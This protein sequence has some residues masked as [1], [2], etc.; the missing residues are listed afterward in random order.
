MQLHHTLRL[1]KIKTINSQ[2]I[3]LPGKFKFLLTFLFAWWLVNYTR[4][5]S[6]LVLSPHAVI[7]LNQYSRKNLQLT[8]TKPQIHK[9][10]K[11]S[12]LNKPNYFFY[13]IRSTLLNVKHFINCV[14]LYVQTNR[15]EKL[16]QK[17]FKNQIPCP[18]PPPLGILK[19]LFFLAFITDL[20]YVWW[21]TSYSIEKFLFHSIILL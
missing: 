10:N 16:T 12:S 8:K 6:P 1:T 5:L 18:L 13:E 19:F 4:N 14:F 20:P 2:N 3:H 7:G 11:E 15:C 21:Y 9:G 17:I